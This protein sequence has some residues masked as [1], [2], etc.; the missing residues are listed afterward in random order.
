LKVFRDAKSS[1][2]G[3]VCES[4]FNSRGSA[5]VL[6]MAPMIDIIFLLLI[7]FLLTARFRPRENFLPMQLEIGGLSMA[8]R[9]ALVEPLT[10]HISPAQDGCKVIL[11][12]D[13]A[14]S[15]I[16]N[17]PET[18]LSLMMDKLALCL[19]QQKRNTGDPIE[20]VCD[21][22]VEWQHL[23]GIYNVLFGMGITNIT[24]QMTD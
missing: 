5:P 24:F 6:R 12:R 22:T 11:G 2:Q 7:F 4:L 13:L 9:S 20:I 23:A 1:I 21:G 8:G 19:Q 10:M 18:G 15:I 17:E 3:K 14:V 16:D